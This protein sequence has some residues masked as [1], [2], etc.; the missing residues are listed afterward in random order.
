MVAILQGRG[1]DLVHLDEQVLATLRYDVMLGA[2]P[3]G[4]IEPRNQ[5]VRIAELTGFYMRPGEVLPGR[6]TMA[7]TTLLGIA[8]CAQAVV[9]N[10]P[11][12]GRS[13]WSKPYQLRL[14]A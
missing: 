10:R 3:T 8:S 5:T 4:W 6:A 12:A 14:I 9:V 7:S 1:I 2:I 11:S 13:N